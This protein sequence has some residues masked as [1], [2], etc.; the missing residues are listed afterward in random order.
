MN[1]ELWWERITGASDFIGKISD[2]VL[3]GKSVI[4]YFNGEIPW[5]NEMLAYTEK[6]IHEQDCMRAFDTVEA[7]TVD[8]KK[9]DPVG[10]YFLEKFCPKNIR[11][12][13]RYNMSIADFMA[14]RDDISINDTNLWVKNIEDV[15]FEYWINFIT[16]YCSYDSNNNKCRFILMID[17]KIS[18]PKLKRR[19][20]NIDVIEWMNNI[21]QYDRYVFS[22]LLAADNGKLMP[23]VKSY[24]AYLATEIGKSDVELSAE[25]INYG[26]EFI[27][28]VGSAIEKIKE[29]SFRSDGKKFNREYSE[30]DLKKFIWHAQLSII[31]PAIEEFRM[32]FIE[33]HKE[34]IAVCLPIETA[35]G[36]KCEIPEEVEIGMLS[37]LTGTGKISI[38]HEEKQ[39]LMLYKN[40]R[41][42]LAH[43]NIVEHSGLDRILED[44]YRHKNE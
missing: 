24:A 2:S 14:G 26:N 17:S 32:K 34:E 40:A 41:N 3:K 22:T 5:F 20:K 33:K 44:I 28:D 9:E 43:S 11:S 38:N 13:R 29:S 16:E 21:T 7:N 6:R 37:Y 30:S 18:A 39:K 4:V 15:N 35:Y 42:S 10:Q 19:Y 12:N 23:Y 1:G 31:F 8:Y 36:E 27:R 25:L